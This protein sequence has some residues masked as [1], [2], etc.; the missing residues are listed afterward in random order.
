M[1]FRIVT[2]G[3]A[4]PAERIWVHDWRVNDLVVTRGPCQTSEGP[5]LGTSATLLVTGALLV[6]TRSYYF[7]FNSNSLEISV[8]L[9]RLELPCLAWS[10]CSF[11]N[12]TRSG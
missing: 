9:R 10:T 11:E 7:N 8:V 2:C 3:S 4:R 12:T 1:G 6:V 5:Q